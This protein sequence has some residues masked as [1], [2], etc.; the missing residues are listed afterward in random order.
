MLIFLFWS[1]SSSS[2]GSSL[3]STVVS[4]LAL[5]GRFTKSTV[6]AIFLN[7]SSSAEAVALSRLL[8]RLL[9]P[10]SFFT[11][12]SEP[13]RD[14]LSAPAASRS[15]SSPRS[16]SSPFY[17]SSF[18]SISSFNMS[19]AFFLF[20]ALAFARATFRDLRHAC[21]PSTSLQ[22]LKNLNVTRLIQSTVGWARSGKNEVRAKLPVVSPI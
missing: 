17:S 22:R 1:P 15:P 13:L 10:E 8:V 7:F 20:S 9:I 14:E 16:W 21:I 2:S 12:P 11:I 19:R 6:A 3:S 4:S 5:T 18:F